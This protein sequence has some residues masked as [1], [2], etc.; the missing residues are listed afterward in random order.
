MLC[1]I[2]IGFMTLP[3]VFVS[4]MIAHISILKIREYFRKNRDT[5]WRKQTPK[6]KEKIDELKTKKGKL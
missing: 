3:I 6:Q 4:Y 2:L 1:K 5:T